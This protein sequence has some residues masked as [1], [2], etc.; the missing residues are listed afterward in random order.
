MRKIIVEIP[1][2]FL[3]AVL[4]LPYATAQNAGSTSPAPIPPAIHNAKKIF[5]SNAGAD[6][7]LFPH[8][9]TGDTNRAYNQFYAALQASKLYKLVSDPYEADL[10]LELRLTAPYGPQNADKQKGASDPL[11]EFHLVV[12]QESTHY[13]LWAFTKAIDPA[14]LQET[15]DRNFD[16]ALHALITDFEELSGKTPPLQP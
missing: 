9:F 8:P 16:N 1:L 6:C 14:L 3:A 4:A 7:G 13:V 12:Y 5:V 10:V 11:P 2:L 15:H